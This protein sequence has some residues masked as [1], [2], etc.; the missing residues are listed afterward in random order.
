MTDPDPNP[1]P[2]GPIVVVVGQIFTRARAGQFFPSFFVAFLNSP[3]PETPKN[4]K[5]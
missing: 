5:T 1:D 2:I 3:N 4:Q